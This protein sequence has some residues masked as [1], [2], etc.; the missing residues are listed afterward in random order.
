MRVISVL[1][2]IKENAPWK[3]LWELKSIK[4]FQSTISILASPF[5]PIR[6]RT[7]WRYTETDISNEFLRVEWHPNDSTVLS[8]DCETGLHGEDL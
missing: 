2:R 6:Q 7:G 4:Q 3:R 1:V 8:L 5:I